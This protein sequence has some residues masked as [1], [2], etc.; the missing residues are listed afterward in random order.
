VNVRLGRA[1]LLLGQGRWEPAEGELRAALGEDPG[2]PEALAL[3]ALALL[4]RAEG[5]DP[6]SRRRLDEAERAAG[7]A[8]AA[9]PDQ[10]FPHH[11]RGR[12]LLARRREEE[13]V[14]AAL[15]AIRLQPEEPDHRALLGQA[16]FSQRRWAEAL[17]AAEEG[18]RLDPEDAAC[19]RLRALAL[20]QSGRR[21]EASET[22]R[23]ALARDPDDASTHT[24][25]G[26]A[27]LEAGDAQAALTHFQEALRLDPTEEGARAGIVEALKARHRLYALFLRYLMFMAKLTPGQQWGI[28][29]GGWLAYRG[30]WGVTKDRPELAPWLYPL[31]GLYLAFVLLSWLGRPLFNLALRLDRF[32]RHA[33]SDDQRQGANLVGAALGAALLAIG[34]WA[35][36]GHWL[37]SACALG[38]VLLLLPLS[39][40]HSCDPGWPRRMMTLYTLGLGACGL[41]L[42]A[43]G[44]LPAPPAAAERLVGLLVNVF[45]FGSLLS[46]FVA[47]ALVAAR[48]QR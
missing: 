10:A 13:A 34:V 23:A 16:R 29:I 27:R 41:A 32:G 3:L 18:L 46:G 44:L 47:N 22:L 8:V 5:H 43:I 38:A 33:L 26:W 17:A 24:A 31:I 12:V 42:L 9:A 35:A 6:D 37:A 19:A 40:I 15:E 36:T 30:L 14:A 20:V 28:V 25:L 48:P 2:D 1:R 21:E 4:G 39:A 45:L 7:D 11:V